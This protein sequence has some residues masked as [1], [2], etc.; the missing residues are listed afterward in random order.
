MGRG[1]DRFRVQERWGH[2]RRQS[3]FDSYESRP[4]FVFFH[5]FRKN[6][7]GAEH[8]RRPYGTPDELL[9]SAT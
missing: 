1:S 3:G 7:G 8:E 2:Q 5:S 4:R 6:D 9:V